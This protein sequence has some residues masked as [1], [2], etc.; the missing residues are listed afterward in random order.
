MKTEL[1]ISFLKNCKTQAN[2]RQTHVRRKQKHLPHNSKGNEAVKNRRVRRR[3]MSLLI[4]LLKCNLWSFQLQGKEETKFPDM[5]IKICLDVRQNSLFNAKK[6]NFSIHLTLEKVK[7][8]I[9]LGLFLLFFKRSSNPK[10]C[11]PSSSPLFG[12]EAECSVLRLQVQRCDWQQTQREAST[13]SLCPLANTKAEIWRQTHTHT[14]HFPVF[15]KAQ[16]VHRHP[17]L[18]Q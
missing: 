16:C 12:W 1:S 6:S 15:T 13:P 14:S 17:T 9:Q 11:E 8:S 3:E 7:L 5:A 4:S 2:P 10:R 18:H